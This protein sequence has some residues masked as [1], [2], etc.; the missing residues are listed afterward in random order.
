MNP[1]FYDEDVA[2]DEQ[3]VIRA[4]IRTQSEQDQYVFWQR[5]SKLIAAAAIAVLVGLLKLAGARS[6]S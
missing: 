2:P 5:W 4:P 3:R 6:L 1:H